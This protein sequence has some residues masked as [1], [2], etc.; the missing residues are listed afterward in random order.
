MT[1]IIISAVIAVVCFGVAGYLFWKKKSKALMPQFISWGL[2]AVEK[3]AKESKNKYD[4]F[5]VSALRKILEN[6]PKADIKKLEKEIDKKIK[7]W[8]DI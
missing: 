1:Q 3:I 2:D 5:A 4:D 8:G 7:S 6:N